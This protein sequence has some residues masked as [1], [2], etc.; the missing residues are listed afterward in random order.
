M[1]YDVV[2]HIGIIRCRT[3]DLPC[4]RLARIQMFLIILK[5][6]DFCHREA[7]SAFR[8]ARA[9]PFWSGAIAPVCLQVDLG[10]VT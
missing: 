3:S 7:P 4:R 6:I 1:T 5:K 2:R 9:I 10:T 8:A